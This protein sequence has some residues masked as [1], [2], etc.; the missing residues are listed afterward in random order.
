MQGAKVLNYA[1]ISSVDFQINP[2]TRIFNL[3]QIRIWSA[4][5]AQ[6]VP[7]TKVLSKPEAAFYLSIPDG[8]HLQN[9]IVTKKFDH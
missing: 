3:G 1:S 4:S 7:G 6:L 5:P 9:I 2:I 8:K